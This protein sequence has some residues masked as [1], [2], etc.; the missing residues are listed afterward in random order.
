MTNGKLE[1]VVRTIS[2][3]YTRLQLCNNV[4]SI[5]H[6]RSVKTRSMQPSWRE[7]DREQRLD[8]ARSRRDGESDAVRAEAIENERWEYIGRWDGESD[9]QRER[10]RENKGCQEWDAEAGP[11]H[12]T[13]HKQNYTWTWLGWT[14][15]LAFNPL[16][17]MYLQRLFQPWEGYC[18]IVSTTNR[19]NIAQL[20]TI[21]NYNVINAI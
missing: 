21:H 12:W 19:G 9:T 11:L 1:M 17:L 16:L 13:A 3:V 14:V 20:S 5:K 15:T 7:T 18:T 8:E 10:E 4:V 6:A 2:T